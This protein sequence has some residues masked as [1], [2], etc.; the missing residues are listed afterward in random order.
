VNIINF[1]TIQI[2]HPLTP[3]TPLGAAIPTIRQMLD[4]VSLD[5]S[6]EP[7]VIVFI[8]MGEPDYGSLKTSMGQNMLARAS[9][10]A[11]GVDASPTTLNSIATVTAWRSIVP[12]MARLPTYAGDV[13]SDICAAAVPGK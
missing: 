9:I 5:R 3:S 2:S 10:V 4:A 11:V 12:D 7:E 1:L 6:L 8:T 13:A